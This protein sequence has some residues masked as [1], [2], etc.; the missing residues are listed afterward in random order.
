[1]L[2]FSGLFSWWPGIELTNSC[3]PSRYVYHWANSLAKLHIYE[4][5]QNCR[6]LIPNADKDVGQLNLIH[7]AG[8]DTKVWL[9]W[10][11]ETS[12]KVQNTL[13]MLPWWYLGILQRGKKNGSPYDD[14]SNIHNSFAPNNQKLDTKMPTNRWR[15]KP[16]LVSHAV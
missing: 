8:G 3:L 16:I 13:T 5:S 14:L 1:M 6:L 9:L 7:T 2:L 12:C 15:D 11:V 10:K 4:N